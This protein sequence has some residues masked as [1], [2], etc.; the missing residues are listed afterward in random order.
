MKP[1]NHKF[2]VP[3]VRRD[4]TPE[5]KALW[6]LWLIL[7]TSFLMSYRVLGCSDYSTV[8]LRN[9]SNDVRSGC[10]R[11]TKKS[12]LLPGFLNTTDNS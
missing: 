2:D 5:H 1:S 3:T 4:R 10:G 11:G 7:T 6:G 12:R 8:R 9:A